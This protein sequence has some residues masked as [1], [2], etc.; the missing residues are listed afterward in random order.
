MAIY[1]ATIAFPQDSDLP[2]DR[3]SINP[4]YFGDNAQGLADALKANLI[5]AP[6]IGAKPFTI[7]I[8]DAQKAPP[9]F[10]LAMAEQIG[11]APAGSGPREVAL[12]LSYY[13][14][15]NRPRY[16]GRLYL[17]QTIWGG[18]MGLRPTVGQQTNV[19][20]FRTVLGSNLPAQHNWVVYSP[21]DQKSYTISNVWCDDEW[22]IVR[23]RG[24]RGTSRV[25]GTVP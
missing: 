15:W 5:A 21:T 14:T 13:S 24:L 20:G 22:D 3:I 11:T 19:V 8:Y 17:P 6:T 12:C 1:R 7:K 2:R 25:L 9:N 10:P 23:S 4:H 16:R 18:A